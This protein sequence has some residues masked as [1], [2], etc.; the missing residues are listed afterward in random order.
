[1]FINSIGH[2]GQS[3]NYWFAASNF[4]GGVSLLLDSAFP[5]APALPAFSAVIL[6]NLLLFIELTFINKAIAEFVGRGR[7][8]WHYLLALSVLTTVASALLPL[9]P[10]TTPSAWP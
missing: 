4:C 8:L 10:E 7:T 5:I 6:A 1:M 2:S 3:G 9:S